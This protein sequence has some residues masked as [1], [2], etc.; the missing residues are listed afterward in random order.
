MDL[1]KARRT[2]HASFIEKQLSQF[3]WP[4]RLRFEKDSA[5]WGSLP[6]LTDGKGSLPIQLAV[7]IEN[8]FIMKNHSEIVK[9]IEDNIHLAI[10]DENLLMDLIAYIKHVAVYQALRS[11]N[12]YS[13]NPI[14][15]GHSF[16]KGL[17]PRIEEKTADLQKEFQQSILI[18]EQSDASHSRQ[19]MPD[20]DL[21]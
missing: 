18:M 10:P 4:I 1:E 7:R 2:A 6:H 8:E 15:L 3:Y 14:G 11:S 9:I 19:F 12:D 16:P 17:I 21:A 20:P 13:N 5:M